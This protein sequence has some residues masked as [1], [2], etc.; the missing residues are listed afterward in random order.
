MSMAWSASPMTSLV[1]KFPVGVITALW[2]L[3]MLAP[4]IILWVKHTL[5]ARL[6][7]E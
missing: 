6:R 5:V 1:L 7:A 2:A 4:G 3:R